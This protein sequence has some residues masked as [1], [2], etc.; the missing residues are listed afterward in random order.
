MSL[1]PPNNRNTV[2]FN[3][4]P[5]AK[6][7][8]GEIPFGSSTDG[9]I[10]RDTFFSNELTKWLVIKHYDYDEDFLE[11]VNTIILDNIKKVISLAMS[12]DDLSNTIVEL[13]IENFD[14]SNTKELS[15]KVESFL[16]LKT[17]QELAKAVGLSEDEIAEI[18]IR[19]IENSFGS[20]RRLANQAKHEKDA[21]LA[22]AGSQHNILEKMMHL[23]EGSIQKQ[24]REERV[25]QQTQA[26]DNSIYSP[27]HKSK[28]P[29]VSEALHDLAEDF[30]QRDLE[31]GD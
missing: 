21:S 3:L 4:R 2:S 19:E 24:Q 6:V 23:I 13:G 22:L 5:A 1:I 31:D 15:T 20:S 17:L 28:T 16:A 7:T 14:V 26:K 29:D 8:H 30:K 10:M 9:I 18:S 12:L 25:K 11:S 27:K